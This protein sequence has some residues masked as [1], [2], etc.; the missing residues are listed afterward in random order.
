MKMKKIFSS[1]ISMVT[2]VSLLAG[3]VSASWDLDEQQAVEG[4]ISSFVQ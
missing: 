2:A 4:D 3:S 1:V